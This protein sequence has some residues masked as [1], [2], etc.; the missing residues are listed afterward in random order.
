MLDSL[1]RHIA[2]HNDNVAFAFADDTYLIAISESYEVNC[3]I[4]TKLFNLVIAWAKENGVELN[5]SKFNLTHFQR[6]GT[7]EE[8]ILDVPDILGLPE[9]IPQPSCRVLGVF[10]DYRLN[11]AKHVAEVSSITDNSL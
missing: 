6:P 5:P 8:K 3:K 9:E 4:I 2:P 1:S 10:L 11:W 7:K